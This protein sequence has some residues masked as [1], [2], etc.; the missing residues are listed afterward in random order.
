MYT[1]SSVQVRRRVGVCQNTYKRIIV[2]YKQTPL[3]AVYTAAVTSLSPSYTAR[4]NHNKPS[5][6]PGNV[7]NNIRIKICHLDE[8]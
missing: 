3:C 2:L 8:H 7:L 6:R 1:C 4:A 5:S